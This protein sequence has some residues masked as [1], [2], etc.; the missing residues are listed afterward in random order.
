MF[1]TFG[2]QV[3]RPDFSHADYVNYWLNVHAP[4]CRNVQQLRGYVANEVLRAGALPGI[5]MTHPQ[6]GSTLDGVAQLHV[7]TRDGLQRLA[8]APEVQRWFSDGPN[9]VG[10]R[11][12]F[13]TEECVLAEPGTSQ[14]QG[15]KAIC[16]LRAAGEADAYW[17]RLRD[18]APQVSGG[19]V[20][21][22]IDTV[23]GST[24]LPGFEVPSV[25]AAVEVWAADEPQAV[26][27]V[28]ALQRQLGAHG[29]LVSALITRETV[30]RMP[31]QQLQAQ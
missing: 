27:A 23:T 24:N 18:W 16:F 26:Q 13:L 5:E 28:A 22:R 12:G 19:L 6:F 2:L 10:M 14:R 4:L 17:R 3:R 1:K 20:C 29:A 30:I 11:T 31:L 21:S 15:F 8:E 7:E 25:D 9:F